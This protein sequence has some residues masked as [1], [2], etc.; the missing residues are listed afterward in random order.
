M[1]RR[2]RQLPVAGIAAGAWKR[3]LCCEQ[4]RLVPLL[5]MVP[6]AVRGRRTVLGAREMFREENS[7][8]PSE[9]PW[10]KPGRPQTQ[11][12]AEREFFEHVVL[13]MPRHTVTTVTI[14]TQ[15]VQPHH[16]QLLCLF[17]KENMV[18]EAKVLMRDLCREQSRACSGCGSEAARP[19]VWCWMIKKLSAHEPFPCCT[20]FHTQSVILC[21]VLRLNKA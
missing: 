3:E 12:K 6:Q 2:Q 19:F 9:I 10:L 5:G 4:G 13:I 17:L 15:M 7:M 18:L 11:S 21:S 16:V 1:S 8:V 14:P 20:Y